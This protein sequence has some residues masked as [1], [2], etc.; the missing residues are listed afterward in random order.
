MALI[1]G[2]LVMGCQRQQEVAHGPAQSVVYLRGTFNNWDTSIPMEYSETYGYLATVDLPAG[3]Y[4]FKFADE[5][6]S[7]IDLGAGSEAARFGDPFNLASGGPN[8]SLQ[9]TEPRNLIFALTISPEGQGSLRLIYG[10]TSGAV[11][12]DSSN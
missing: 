10:D 11:E 8:L 2:L 1:T 3:T 4:E 9:L 12:Q 6:W 7:K 5:G